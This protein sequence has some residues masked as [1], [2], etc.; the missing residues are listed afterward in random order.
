MDASPVLL[1]GLVVAGVL[2]LLLGGALL[3]F[4]LLSLYAG[5]RCRWFREP[6]AHVPPPPTAPVAS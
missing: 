4:L 2:A 6:P 1:V 3:A 5:R